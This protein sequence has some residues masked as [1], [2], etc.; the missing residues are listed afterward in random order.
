MQFVC[1][2]VKGKRE[3]LFCSPG[4]FFSI[5]FHIDSSD[6]RRFAQIFQYLM[7]LGYIFG[8]SSLKP[9][10]PSTRTSYFTSMEPGSSGTPLLCISESVCL[11][12]IKM[13][14]KAEQENSVGILWA[15]KLHSCFRPFIHSFNFFKAKGGYFQ[16]AFSPS[17]LTKIN[18]PLEGEGGVGRKERVELKLL[19]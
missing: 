1:C 18:F 2:T 6:A 4:G 17:I 12:L 7:V 19:H 8:S 16:P 10:P 14:W 9:F 13:F 5:F 3:R 15:D 11:I